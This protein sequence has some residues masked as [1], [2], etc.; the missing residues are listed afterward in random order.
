[1][2]DNLQNILDIF[3]TSLKEEIFDL[4]LSFNFYPYGKL[5][6]IKNNLIIYFETSCT[7]N[8]NVVSDGVAGG[9]NAMKVVIYPAVK[10]DCSLI[11]SNSDS[12]IYSYPKATQCI[13][14]PTYFYGET[15]KN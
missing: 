14:Y 15:L 2:Y 10:H 9:T 11:T 5:N 4:F 12:Q 6:S 3:L 7:Q 8:W 13:D 1:M